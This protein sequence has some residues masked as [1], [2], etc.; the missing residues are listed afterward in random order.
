MA[1]PIDAIPEKTRWEI[2]T[3]GMTGAYTAISNAF[4]QALGQGKFDEFNGGLWYQAGKGAKEF[5]ANVGLPT[6]TAGDLEVV[7][8]LMAQA[9]RPAQP[10]PIGDVSVDAKPATRRTTMVA[11]PRATNATMRSWKRA[12]DTV[13]LLYATPA[14]RSPW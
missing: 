6:E 9:A 10:V 12:K 2:A 8:H 3:K 13:I 5:A 7:T 1:K 14:A 4:F 11:A